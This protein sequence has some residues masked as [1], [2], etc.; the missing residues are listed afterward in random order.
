MAEPPVTVP[1]LAAMKARG[2]KIAVLTAYDALFARLLDESGVEVVLVGDSLGMVIQGH[3]STLQTSLDE[4]VYHTRCA[5]RGV[6]RALLVADLPFMSYPTPKAAADSAARLIREGGAR[7]V[8]LEGGRS[9][10]DTVRFLAE[11]SIP[12]CGHLGL[13]PQS[14]HQL[15]GYQVQARDNQAAQTLLE[16]AL[17]LQEAGLGMLVLECVPASLGEEVSRALDIPVI[18]IGAGQGCDGQVLVLHDMLGLG[19]GKRPRFVKDFLTG[20]PDI[21]SAI[22]A[23]VAAVKDGAFPAEEHG[24]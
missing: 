20:Q 21:A 15:G 19:F 6:V 2:E 24:F 22:R 23:Y 7:M 5:A 12:V 9:R 18:G 1:G 16:D 4:M 10:L 17:L 13:L 14:V 3:G 8:K 11:Q